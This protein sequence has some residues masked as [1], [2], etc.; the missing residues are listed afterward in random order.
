MVKG[1]SRRVIVVR[2][3]DPKVFE[4]AI[5]LL[6]EDNPQG[7][8]PEA[9]VLRQAQEVADAYLLRSSPKARW[10]R[11]LRPLLFALLGAAAATVLWRFLPLPF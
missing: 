2:S 7:E 11:A 6:R 1:V 8:A 4:Q 10:R 5:F 3:P 9:A